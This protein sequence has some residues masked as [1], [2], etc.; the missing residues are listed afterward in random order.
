MSPEIAAGLYDARC[1]SA[2]GISAWKG[3]GHLS[4]IWLR[5]DTPTLNHFDDIM[6]YDIMFLDMI[7]FRAILFDL[8]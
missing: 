2:E 3:D 6:P 7:L 8:M 5:W 1:S 4:L